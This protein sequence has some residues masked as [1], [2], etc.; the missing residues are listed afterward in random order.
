MISVAI[1]LLVSLGSALAFHV[2]VADVVK[3]PRQK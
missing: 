3:R 2:K 1:A